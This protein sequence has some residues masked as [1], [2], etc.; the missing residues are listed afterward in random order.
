MVTSAT[1]PASRST[2][3]SLNSVSGSDV[4]PD[5]RGAH[6]HPDAERGEPVA[7]VRALAEAVLE[8]RQQP[9]TGRGE[10]VTARDRAAVRIQALVLPIDAEAGPPADHLD[11]E[12]LVQ[13]EEAKIVEL[14]AR[15]LE[16]LPGRRPRPEPH[17]LGLR[18]H[19]GIRDEA[20]SRL[21]RVLARA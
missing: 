6:A 17:Q 12:G 21:E 10:R 16:R 14:E 4:L 2:A 1:R 9:D 3:A 13:L 11:S 18:A 15:S 8:L 5:Q 7:H 19:E 20:H